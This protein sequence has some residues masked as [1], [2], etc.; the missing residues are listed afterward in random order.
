MQWRNEDV[1]SHFQTA[2]R[3]LCPDHFV[4]AS[5]SSILIGSVGFI[6]S[7]DSTALDPESILIQGT[8][9]L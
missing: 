8:A 2:P 1:P 3:L 5:A 7:I 4:P 6:Y 9:H